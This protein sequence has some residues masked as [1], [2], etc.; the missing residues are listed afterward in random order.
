MFNL[1]SILDDHQKVLQ[2]ERQAK[3]HSSVLPWTGSSSRGVA[4]QKTVY[5]GGT[6]RGVAGKPPTANPVK[7]LDS[8]ASH[9]FKCGKPGHR[10]AECKK[11]TVQKGLF[12]DNE[13]MVIVEL[14]QPLE[15]LIDEQADKEVMEE[16][17]VTRDDGPLLVICSA[18]LTPCETSGNGWVRSNIFQSK[19]IV[20]GKVC[21]F[22]IDSRSC[23]NMISEE[24]V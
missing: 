14:E 19:F 5:S 21:K 8:Y 12:I 15:N 9:Y 23:E 17:H 2:L 3:W 16:E 1:Y 10:F 13:G 6:V 18:C 22:M 20:R 7:P 11:T 24:A 4:Q